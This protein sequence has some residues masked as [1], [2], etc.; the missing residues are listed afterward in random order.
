MEWNSCF[1][2]G[3]STDLVGR[4]GCAGVPAALEGDS[5]ILPNEFVRITE[6][7]FKLS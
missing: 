1:V 5:R 3:Q 4:S 7:E 6:T 2:G